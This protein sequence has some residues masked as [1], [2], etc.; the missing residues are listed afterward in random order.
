MIDVKGI[1]ADVIENGASDLHIN[2]KSWRGTNI[3]IRD[4]ADIKTPRRSGFMQQMWPVP[5]I[6]SRWSDPANRGWRF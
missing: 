4:L 6:L 2:S 3:S 5:T 1:L